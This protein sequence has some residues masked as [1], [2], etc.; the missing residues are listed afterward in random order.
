MRYSAD[1]GITWSEEHILIENVADN[2]MAC[3]IP[4]Y[5]GWRLYYSSDYA[6]IGASY[7]GASVYYADFDADFKKLTDYQNVDMRDNYSV[8][9]YEV[10]ELNHRLYFMYSH[11]YSTDKDFVLK[12]CKKQ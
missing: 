5:E 2:E 9:L 12:S 4:E 8:R 3:M 6:D 11:N 10:K 7:N 1:E